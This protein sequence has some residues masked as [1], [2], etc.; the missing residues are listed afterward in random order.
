LVE[1]LFDSSFLMA[2][3]EHPTDWLDGI[4]QLVGA[5]EPVVLS[6]TVD[7]LRRISEGKNKKSKSAALALQLA[8]GFA[9]EPSGSGR[10]D[11]EIVSSA[12]AKRAVVAALDRELIRTLRARRVR[13]VGLKQGR[14]ALL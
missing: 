5:V 2:V 9:V 12:L 1:V 4:T 6:C 14:A 8:K 3:A 7:E 13:V 10:V 11:D